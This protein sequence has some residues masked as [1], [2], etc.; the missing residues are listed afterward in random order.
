MSITIKEGAVYLI[1]GGSG[2]LGSALIERILS[3]GGKIR[4]LSRN[5]GNLIKLKAKYPSIEIY[6]GDI[7]DL[8]EIKQACKGVTGIFH[9]AAFKH[10]GMAE[11]F[12]K[13][14]IK[15]N[16]IGS[17]NV[18]DITL[19]NPEIEFVKGI[20]T[21]KACQVAGVYGASKFLMEALFRQYES[22]NP[23]C[24]YRLVR[25]GNV[26]YST[27][28]VL[29]K[30]KDLI[31][32]GEQCIVTDPE[33]TRFYWTVDQAIDLIFEGLEKSTSS[34]PFCPSMK[35]VKIA[36]LLTAMYTKYGNG[37]YKEP[38][39]IGLQRGENLHE[40]IL[41]DGPFSNEVENYTVEELMALI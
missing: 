15:S 37:I 17:M 32:K 11:Q 24:Q 8:F 1:T 21:D 39:I 22:L 31:E 4:V 12:S 6:P 20:S 18:L 36:D 19:E 41:E 2:F 27:G 25:Y 23:H 35:S 34:E 5:E 9:L 7:T 3:Q 13:E 28:S 14:C 16:V 26:L 10:V 33:A 38:K 40:K 29:C 30:W